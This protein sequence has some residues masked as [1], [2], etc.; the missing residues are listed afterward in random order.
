MLMDGTDRTIWRFR[1]RRMFLHLISAVLTYMALFVAF[2]TWV[3]SERRDFREV[4]IL[5]QLADIEGPDRNLEFK[6]MLMWQGVH[7]APGA[8]GSGGKTYLAS[9]GKR[10][11]W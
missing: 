8:T 1:M 4:P 7:V 5:E 10:V 11:T 9:D 6:E 2:G 3:T